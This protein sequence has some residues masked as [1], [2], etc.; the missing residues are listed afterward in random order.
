MIVSL[1]T[2]DGPEMMTSMRA[3]RAV[4]LRSPS[5]GLARRRPSLNGP[6]RPQARRARASSSGGSGAVARMRCPSDGDASSSR[7]AWRNSRSSPSGPAPRRPGPVDRVAGD[8]VADRVEVDAD[9][10][11]PAGDEVELEQRPAGEPLADAVAGHRRPPVGTTRHPRPVLRVAPDRRLDPPDRRRHAALDERQVRLLDP[12]RL[13]LR[14]ERGLRRV[15]PG[16]HQ[17]PA[18]VA[19]EA[20]DDARAAATPAIPPQ[21]DAVAAGEERVDERVA[22]VAGRRDGRRGRPACRR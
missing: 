7:Q 19:V 11:R 8:R 13:E 4:E 18:R 14:H 20:M 12:A 2:P 21:V 1:P 3:G 5:R 10:V 6:P 22:R 9:L 16:D 17:Q 15:V